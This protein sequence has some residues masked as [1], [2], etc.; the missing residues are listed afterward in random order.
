MTKRAFKMVSPESPG[1]QEQEPLVGDGVNQQEKTPEQRPPKETKEYTVGQKIE[2]LPPGTTESKTCVVVKIDKGG[3]HVVNLEDWQTSEGQIVRLKTEVYF[4]PEA[5]VAAE[6]RAALAKQADRM[7]EGILRI[8]Q[9]GPEA[10]PVTD[11]TRAII[12]SETIHALVSGEPINERLLEKVETK[13]Q[14]EDHLHKLEQD[15][16]NGELDKE[17]EARAKSLGYEG[18]DVKK[19]V[20]FLK[21]HGSDIFKKVRERLETNPNEDSIDVLEKTIGDY[22]MQEEAWSNLWQ[23]AEKPLRDALSVAV[24]QKREQTRAQLNKSKKNVARWFKEWKNLAL[25]TTKKSQSEHGIDQR[26]QQVYAEL[27]E[28]L[29]Q[30]AI[31]QQELYPTLTAQDSRLRIQIQ[32]GLSETEDLPDDFLITESMEEVSYV[33]LKEEFEKNSDKTAAIKTLLETA[34]KNTK[35]GRCASAILLESAKGEILTDKEIAEQ[36]AAA[37]LVHEEKD[38]TKASFTARA[39]AQKLLDAVLP[40]TNLYDPE[41]GTQNYSPTEEMKKF[42]SYR[43]QQLQKTRELAE[44]LL[45]LRIGL[46]TTREDTQEKQNL[47]ADIWN[48]EKEL[49][50]M[51]TEFGFD[52]QTAVDSIRSLNAYGILSNLVL[53]SKMP[54]RVILTIESYAKDDSSVS[55]DVRAASRAVLND[56]KTGR[57]TNSAFSQEQIEH[58]QTWKETDAY[59]ITSEKEQVEEEKHEEVNFDIREDVSE[60]LP[61]DIINPPII[62]NPWQRLKIGV[63][64]FFAFRKITASEAQDALSEQDFPETLPSPIPIEIPQ[65]EIPE[66]VRN[67]QL[68]SKG[69]Q[70]IRERLNNFIQ[71]SATSS[72]FDAYDLALNSSLIIRAQIKKLENVG[73]DPLSDLAV[74]YAIARGFTETMRGYE[75]NPKFSELS[76]QTREHFSQLQEAFAKIEKNSRPSWKEEENLPV[77]SSQLV[78][79]ESLEEY[80]E[81]TGEKVELETDEE[82]SLEEE[83]PGEEK[84]LSIP[85]PT[86][87][88]VQ[89]IEEEEL[90]DGAVKPLSEELQDLYELSENQRQQELE[91]TTKLAEQAVKDAKIK[92][93]PFGALEEE[94]PLET[95]ERRMRPKLERVPSLQ[96]QEQIRLQQEYDQADQRFQRAV[97]HTRELEK[98]YNAAWFGRA[99][100]KRTWELAKQRQNILLQERRIAWKKLYPR[101]TMPPSPFVEEAA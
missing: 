32:T 72:K 81:V 7:I 99:K 61:A 57:L 3:I 59:K 69:A 62:Q 45:Q 94:E 36:I 19:F 50:I 85:R 65:G 43:K 29:A 31:I 56:L 67:Y 100:K 26:W 84:D 44:A 35:I 13:L 2:I 28:A 70:L 77:D 10:K 25:E 51:S 93:L 53:S 38:Y 60:R 24:L 11:E 66:T 17:L 92:D 88:E 73:D 14:A 1:T 98:I 86:E 8:V 82:P 9:T 42:R 89:I 23:E 40:G 48:I 78:G 101:E 6:K 97:D 39:T 21:I 90:P 34:K 49:R 47:M 91:R 64:K 68:N 63:A 96:E 30:A 83:Q 87:A 33:R 79:N 20:G 58:M 75:S 95:L 54:D 55:P 41:T 16:T 22:M 37:I 4:P 18:E 71:E 12:R 80:E 46:R 5:L 52:D 27:E 76:E 74:A 15:W